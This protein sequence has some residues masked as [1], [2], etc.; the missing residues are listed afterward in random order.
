[1]SNIVLDFEKPIIELEKR[2]DEMKVY[3]IEENV[4]LEDEIK[5]LEIRLHKLMK[6]TYSKLSRWQRYQ[7]AKHPDRP[8]T[9]DYIKNIFTDFVE[10]HGDRYFGDDPALV[11][12]L[13]QLD[14]KP[15][16]VMG[17]QKESVQIQST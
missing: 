6:E 11:A 4:E 9:K 10:M 5:R 1:M 13:S 17:Q 15:V 8:F 7:L 14:G 12:G 16:M 2:I 3:A